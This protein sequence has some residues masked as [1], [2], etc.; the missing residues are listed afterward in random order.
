MAKLLVPQ[1][2]CA[3]IDVDGRRYRADRNGQV[4]V[5]DHLVKRLK[6]NGELF[7]PSHATWGATGFFCERCGFHAVFRIC[8]R[9]GGTC[10][11]PDEVDA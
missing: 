5:P 7:S 9:C 3:G 8:G 4:E 11:R 2:A 6:A 10:H 1:S